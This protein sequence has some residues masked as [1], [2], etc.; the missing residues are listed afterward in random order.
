MKIDWKMLG[1]IL[2][3]ALV[4]TV[5]VMGGKYLAELKRKEKPEDERQ[6]KMV[7]IYYL[8]PDGIYKVDSNNE[9]EE[10]VVEG[11]FLFY[12]LYG[13]R[14]FDFMG[15]RQ[16]YLV[17]VEQEKF[18]GVEKWR[19]G[20]S[21]H[22]YNVE[23]QEEI[24]SEEIEVG[25]SVLEF[26]ISPDDQRMVFIKQ[27]QRNDMEIDRE[28]LIWE[29]E[30]QMAEKWLSE[31]ARTDGPSVNLS[32]G[33]WLNND[34]V[35]IGKMY[36]GGSYC[37]LSLSQDTQMPDNCSGMGGLYM[38]KSDIVYFGLDEYAYGSHFMNFNIRGG[39]Q[40]EKQGLYKMGIVSGE[41]EYFL[42]DLGRDLVTDGQ[43]IYF[44]N[45]NQ[46]GSYNAE[47]NSD[48]YVT[49]VNGQVVERL[50]NNGS[51]LATKNELYLSNNGRYLSYFETDITQQD[52]N[53]TEVRFKQS[54]VWIYD[55]QL[56]ELYKVVN[57]ALQPIVIVRE[58]KI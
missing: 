27:Y 32:L 19:W 56:D 46:E 43:K 14:K 3:F 11:N 37:T 9:V 51:Q 35:T 23:R 8:K 52:W 36:E 7:E 42:D 58:S 24:W 30:S 53:M 13:K 54:S 10:K 12:S 26:I 21:L 49:D 1:K 16:Q 22:I 41:R 45:I 48:L 55:V 25:E 17:Y 5:M 44:F 33:T 2:L 50:S 39:V 34:E 57:G 18:E 15:D 38:D 20:Q 40:K 6:Q 47:V 4:S 29:V 31:L 28:I